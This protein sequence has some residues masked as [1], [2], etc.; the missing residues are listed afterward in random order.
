MLPYRKEP[1]TEIRMTKV[2]AILPPNQAFEANYVDAGGK[3]ATFEIHAAYFARVM[4]R[5]GIV[6][7]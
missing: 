6:T 5:A 1:A 4:G 7:N 3:I 2:S